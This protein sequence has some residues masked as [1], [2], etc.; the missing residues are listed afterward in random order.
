MPL[1]R[2][3]A[4]AFLVP[5]PEPL[6]ASMSEQGIEELAESMRGLGVL[7]PLVVT[8]SDP[9]R[10][11]G[12]QGGFEGELDD[13]YTKG[14]TFEII[15]GHR[16][17]TA[18]ERAGIELLPCSVFF[19]VEQAKFAMMLHANI[20]R[21]DVTPAEEGW[22]FMELS[23][24]HQ[25]S[26]AD[27]VRF[28]HVSEYYI[29][30]RVDLV[31]KDAKVA[32]AVHERLLNL[33]QAKVILKA[34]DPT[35]RAYL[36]EQATVHGAT[37]RSLQ[38]MTQNYAA[39]IAAGQG[40]LRLHTP[41][42]SPAPAGNPLEVC[43]WCRGGA[44]PENLRQVHVH[45]YHKAE[46]DAVVEKLGAHNVLREGVPHPNGGDLSEWSHGKSS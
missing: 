19:D 7:M 27:L 12:A 38:V 3:I 42:N 43:I 2:T 16:R 1:H 41:E 15:D 31:R 46:L 22:Q 8:P 14:G 33:S 32:A 6:R 9:A 36:F 20:C 37:T 4:R 18:A 30:E 17:Y 29:N 24:K 26:M 23:E 44:D 35:L 34:K 5:P 40:D 21:E 45:W 11:R 25:W 10:F 13:Y 28:F 39:D